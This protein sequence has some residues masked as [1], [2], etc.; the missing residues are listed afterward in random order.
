M[1]DFIPLGRDQFPDEEMIAFV[2]PADKTETPIHATVDGHKF[3]IAPNTRYLVA[4]PIFEVA[5]NSGYIVSRLPVDAQDSPPAEPAVDGE[6][7]GGMAGGVQ[8][9]GADS[10]FDADAVIVGT[11]GE[12]T[13]RL[14]ALTPAQL[15]AVRDAEADREVPRKGVVKAI[16][17]LAAKAAAPAA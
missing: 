11:I 15:A 13:A 2:W 16:D 9:A 8:P 14:A 5:E 7:T 1:S 12:V 10:S 3:T 6:G 17:E 4:A